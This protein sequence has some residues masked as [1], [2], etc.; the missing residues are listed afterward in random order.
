[1]TIGILNSNTGNMENIIKSIKYLGYKPI[2]IEERNQLLKISHLIIPGVGSFPKIM[3][4]LKK[5]KMDEVLKD[6]LK[7]DLKIMG[8]CLGMHIMFENSEEL[9]NR[10]G[11]HLIQGNIKKINL[12]NFNDTK[13]YVPNLGYH[14]IQKKNLTN[15]KSLFEKF[16]LENFYFSHSFKV[17]NYPDNNEIYEISYFKENILALI[18]KNKNLIGCQFHPELSGEKGLDFIDT[19]IKWS[20]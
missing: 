7:I 4:N 11:L 5:S 12:S 14:K 17:W 19:F 20:D 16:N 10:K 13:R 6:Y 15:S 1:M 3:D 2:I 9:E 18:I 8:I